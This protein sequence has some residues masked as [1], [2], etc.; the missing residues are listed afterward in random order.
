MTQNPSETCDQW[1]ETEDNFRIFF[2]L[3]PDF[4]FVLNMEGGIILV[5]RTVHDLLGYST[6]ELVGMPVLLLHPEDRRDEAGRIVREMVEGRGD[7]CPIPLLTRDGREVPVETKVMPGRWNGQACLF[8]YSRNLS[9]LKRS[10]EKFRSAF[11]SSSVLMAISTL[12]DGRFLDV[13]QAFT[14]TMGY[15]RSRLIGKSS[16]ELGL[17]EDPSDRLKM[18]RLLK[19]HHKVNNMTIAMRHV[20]GNI[21]SGLFSAALMTGSAGEKLLLTSMV[22]ITGLK[23]AEGKLRES[24]E[25]LQL[26]LS[27]ADLGTWDWDVPTGYVHFNRRWAEMLGYE[28]KEIKPHVETWEKLL[29]PEDKDGVMAALQRHLAGKTDTYKTEHRLWSKSGDPVWVLDTG[30]VIQRDSAGAPL[31]VAGIHMDITDRKQAEKELHEYQ[32]HLEE[33]VRAR[34]RQLEQA[35]KNL[36]AR[37]LEA[38]RA[39]ALDIMLHNIGNAVT[40]ILLQ[41]DKLGMLNR[42]QPLKYLQAC[43]RDLSD[44]RGELDPYLSK[45]PRGREVF[46]Y[47]GRLLETLMGEDRERT[48]EAITAI[49]E[50]VGHISQILKVQSLP[51]GNGG[52]KVRMAVAKLVEYA[53]RIQG[54]A[55]SKRGIRVRTQLEPGLMIEADQ[56]SMCQ[57]LMNL[58]KNAYE[59]LEAMG[60]KTL[61]KEIVIRSFTTEN[62]VFLEISDNGAGLDPGKQATVFETG[63]SGKGSSGFGLFYVKTIVEASGG[64]ILFKS[65][66][67]G[68]GA[69]VRLEFVRDNRPRG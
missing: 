19:E 42:D 55:L 36:L 53:L 65:D 54:P 69:Q 49:R 30:R 17:F 16:L 66:G 57:V 63:V 46:S 21:V 48:R 5:N 68:K 47:M 50:A 39:Q 4:L 59:A 29:H 61:E 33:L 10:E 7:F 41:A 28:P 62:R 9:E 34:T 2:D 35:Q 64:T 45:D 24:E 40:P 38:G 52:I 32:E 27:G 22:D 60:G 15:E 1:T 31:R 58:I 26:V 44:H 14:D 11:A 37:A 56:S 13:N 25:R 8:G 12:E 67:E 43:Y 51:P 3:C 23:E 6:E 18:I 20:N